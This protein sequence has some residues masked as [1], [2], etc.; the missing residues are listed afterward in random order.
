MEKKPNESFR[1]YAQSWRE[2]ATQVQPPLLEKETTMLFINTL[3]A[4]FINHMLGSATKSFLDT[5][6][7]GEMIEN[8]IRCR[9][10]E[11]E[12]STKRSAPR[13]RENEVNNVGTYNRSYSKVVTVNQSRTA[14]IGHQGQPRQESNTRRN[15]EKL[16]FTPI[17]MTYKELY[18]SL[19]DAHVVSPFYLKPM[20][21]PTPSG[22]KYDS[23][24]Y[25]EENQDECC[26]S[27]NPVEKSLEEN[28]RKRVNHTRLEEHVS[29][30]MELFNHLTTKNQRSWSKNCTRVVIRKPVAFPYKDSKRVPWNYDCNVTNPGELGSVSTSEESQDVGFYTCSRRHY[31]APNTKAEPVKWKS[32]VIEQMK[33]KPKLP[34]NEM[35]ACGQ[36][37]HEY[38]LKHSES[39]RRHRKEAGAVPSSLHQKLKLVM[40]GRLITINVEED[41]IASVTS[42]APYIEVDGEVIECSFRSLEFVNATFIVEGSKIPMPKIS[43]IT[44]MSLQQIVGKRTSLGRRLG[45]YLH[46]R[47][48]VPILTNKQDRF[49][50]G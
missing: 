32:L 22:G 3:K 41:I 34:V 12:E 4:P 36:L 1:Q 28:G 30:S 39:I 45:K 14:T 35:V 49:G 8:T 13:K 40:E 27:K 25:G 9:K 48:E 18:Q 50:L 33:E 29:R 21:P 17:P 2:V 19:F 10:I 46:G 26:R 47:V 43:K 15:T 24:E 31:D 37:S 38:M 11:T 23:Q 42:N 7:S 5:V 20:Q 44:R 16:Q 6:M